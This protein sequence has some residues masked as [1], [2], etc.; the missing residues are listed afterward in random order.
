MKY[1]YNEKEKTIAV[2]TN[3][4]YNPVPKGFKEI[5]KERYEELQ[6]ELNKSSEETEATE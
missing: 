5:T 3:F 6:E 4:S 2:A 1:Y